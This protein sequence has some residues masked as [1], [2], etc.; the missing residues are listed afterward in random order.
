MKANQR[1]PQERWE[2]NKERC[3]QVM[4][5]TIAELT[6]RSEADA[7]NLCTEMADTG[8]MNFEG[9]ASGMQEDGD[10]DCNNPFILKI[11]DFLGNKGFNTAE[12][13]TI[14]TAICEFAASTM[15]MEGPR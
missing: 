9:V 10:V 15:L 11:T 8:I 5:A 7:R 12:A 1:T 14:A 4:T 2:D 3:K 6:G 13:Q